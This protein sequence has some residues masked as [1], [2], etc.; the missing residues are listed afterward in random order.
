MCTT[1]PFSVVAALSGSRPERRRMIPRR[2]H[3]PSANSCS[4]R[5]AVSHEPRLRD[6]VEYTGAQETPE[7]QLLPCTGLQ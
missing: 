6:G 3:A 5:P 4:W 7:L 2:K 1:K